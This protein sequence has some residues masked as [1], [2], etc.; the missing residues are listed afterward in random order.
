MKAADLLVA[1]LAAHGVRYVFGVPGDTSTAWYVA[2]DNCREIEHVLATDERSAAFMADAYAKLTNE[3]GVCEGP[4][5]AGFTYM[6]PGISEANDS[7]IP[8]IAINTDIETY[9]R[10]KSRLTEV[11]QVRIAALTTRWSGSVDNVHQLPFLVRKAFL[12]ATGPHPGATHLA[13]PKDIMETEISETSAASE[14]RGSF[15]LPTFRQ[16]PDEEMI[17]KAAQLIVASKK[18]VLIVGGGVHLSQAY[19]AV[20]EFAELI[21]A[22]VATSITG[23]G[24]IDERHHLA[25][26]VLGE[27][28]GSEVADAV[29]READLIIFI[30]TQTGSCVT[31]KWTVPSYSK[32]K[33]FIQIDSNVEE[34]GKNYELNVGLVGDAGATLRALSSMIARECQLGSCEWQLGKEIKKWRETELRECRDRKAMCHPGNLIK[35]MKDLVPDNVLYIADCGTPCPYLSACIES[36]TGRHFLI[37]RA[38][39]G[40]GWAVPATV[41]AHFALKHL[42]EADRKI[43][44]LMGD[45]SMR[46]S[47]NELVTITTQNVNATVILIHNDEYSWVKTGQKLSGEKKHLNLDFPRCDYTGI[48]KAMGFPAEAV[49]NSGSL[50]T[51]LAAAMKTRGPFFIDVASIPLWEELPPVIG[52]RRKAKATAST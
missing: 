31:Q 11:E 46:M 33:E 30:G 45:G 51:A 28:G 37:P 7:S 27:N 24:S 39:G 23:K 21:N 43:V 48:A 8:M 47:M 3:P 42:G 26:G 40:L 44:T 17:R 52:W 2:L 6:L 15:K 35:A 25:V 38:H 49:S 20:R 10:G 5:G 14:T 32:D 4:S 13:L 1:E 12:M 41:G 9:Y 34:V 16:Q 29:V 19:D 36:R 50:R 22:P 18:P